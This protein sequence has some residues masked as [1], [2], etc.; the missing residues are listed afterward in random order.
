MAEKMTRFELKEEM[1][2]EFPKDRESIR[3]LFRADNF[4]EILNFLERA[5]PHCIKLEKVLDYIESDMIGHLKADV[6]Q[7]LEKR[8]RI[9]ELFAICARLWAEQIKA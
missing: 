5:K 2:K 3:E 6:Q 8:D 1:I 9:D 4:L 7:Q